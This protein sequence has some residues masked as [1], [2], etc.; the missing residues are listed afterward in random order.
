[1]SGGVLHF[2]AKKFLA[3]GQKNGGS[4]GRQPPSFS[5]FENFGIEFAIKNSILG[6]NVRK[7]DQNFG[8]KM[9]LFKRKRFSKNLDNFSAKLFLKFSKIFKN[10]NVLK[11]P[12]MGS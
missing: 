3:E 10:L 7:I 12:K 2:H 5:D 11:R 9:T 4:G 1:M 8:P 6:E